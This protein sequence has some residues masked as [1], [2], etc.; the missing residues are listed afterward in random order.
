MLAAMEEFFPEGVEWTRPEGG[1]FLWVRLPEG[2]DAVELLNEAVEQK[3]A[4]VPGYAFYADESGHNTMRLNFSNAAPE[5][6]REGIRRLGRT[7][8]RHMEALKVPA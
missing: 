8:E 5:L 3:V 6:I 1:L 2:M 4:F 7:I